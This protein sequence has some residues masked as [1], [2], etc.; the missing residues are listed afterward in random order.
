M[1]YLL[2]LQLFFFSMFSHSQ[3]YQINKIVVDKNTR[4]PLENVLIFN[5]NDNSTTNAD[6][7][8]VFVSQNSELNL[9]LLG[10]NAI[11]TTFNE[12]N[13]SK[14]TI[15]MENKAFL[16][17]EVVV[18]NTIPFMKKVYAKLKENYLANYT[19][20]FFLRNELKKDNTYQILQDV[21][22]K[23]NHNSNEKKKLSIEILN[24]RKTSLFE[25]KDPVSF[26]FP[27]FNQFLDIRLPYVDKC[28]FTEVPFND[29]EFKKVLFKT[30]E[31][32]EFKQIWNGYII[33]HK[34]DYA[35]VEYSLIKVDNQQIVPFTKTI[36]GARYRTVKS[37][38]FVQF[39]KNKE[40]KK[41]YISNSILE[42]QVE[43][44]IRKKQGNPIYYDL[45][46][47]YFVTN[48]ITSEKINSNFP[49]DKDIFK[50]KFPYS[51]DFW[52]NQNQLPLTIDLQQFLKSVS[53]KKDKTKEYEI[54]GNF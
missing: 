24:M 50:A 36:T 54:I 39:T 7:K 15:F 3:S 34:T 42:Y 17:E 19:A 53:D 12:L 4:L 25:K 2:S 1:K 26:K 38:R 16:L 47:N 49:A 6:G 51:K 20:N 52:N 33:V 40:S 32:D 48:N 8:F 29:Y 37:N 41:Y 9:N 45:K 18:S 23:E 10:Y 14:D 46:M 43:A 5:K 44:I 11:K 35:I 13:N 27:N 30:T 31:K 22:G 21:H 28:E